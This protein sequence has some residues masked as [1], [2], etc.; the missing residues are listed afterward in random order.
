MY[1][2][3]EKSPERDFKSLSQI[4]IDSN[5]PSQTNNVAQCQFAVAAPLFL[6]LKDKY[7]SGFSKDDEII[8]HAKKF[9]FECSVAVY[10]LG[11]TLGYD[12][13]YDAYYDSIKL[14][15]FEEQQQIRNETGEQG[16]LFNDGSKNDKRK[17][18]AWLWKKSRNNTSYKAA[19]D[20]NEIAHLVKNGYNI[21]K[22][23]TPKA[24]EDIAKQGYEVP[25]P[26]EVQGIYKKYG[27][28]K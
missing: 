3:I 14:S 5:L 24:K 11:L 6:F 15:I 16:E 21:L 19:F 4:A 28:R 26:K 20:E 23:L 9:G 13:T 12:K 17:P 22:S 2:L 25:K 10:L 7:S 1:E 18:M 8:C 27:N